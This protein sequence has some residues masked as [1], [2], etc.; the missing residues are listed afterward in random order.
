MR[1]TALLTCALL[2]AAGAGQAQSP[3]SGAPADNSAD[4]PSLNAPQPVDASKATSL[5]AGEIPAPAGPNVQPDVTVTGRRSTPCGR[6]DQACIDSVSAE[7]WKRYPQQIET[8]CSHQTVYAMQQGFVEDEM[9]IDGVKNDHLTP[10]TLALC[11]YGARMKKA[12]LAARAKTSSA[13]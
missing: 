11:E 10:Q 2:L 8:L 12:D 7:I 5:K 1:G 13:P 4:A 6:R 9:G 3:P